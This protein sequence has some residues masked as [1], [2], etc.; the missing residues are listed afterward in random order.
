MSK[1]FINNPLPK[2]ISQIIALKYVESDNRKGQHKT[3]IYEWR[4]RE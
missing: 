1:L 3:Q 2:V 4:M